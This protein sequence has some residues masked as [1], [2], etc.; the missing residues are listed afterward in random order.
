MVASLAG[1]QLTEVEPD[2][3]LISKIAPATLPVLETPEGRLISQ[4]PAICEY[5]AQNHA[6]LLGSTDFERA[7]VDQWISFVREETWPLTKTLAAFTFGSLQCTAT[8]HAFI[9]N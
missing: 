7:Q 8:E 3:A 5:L 1:H 9:Y 2:S 4:T 6:N